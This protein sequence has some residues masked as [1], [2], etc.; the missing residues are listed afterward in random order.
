MVQRMRCVATDL[1][2]I[3]EVMDVHGATVLDVGCG[4]GGLAQRLAGQGA[5]VIGLESLTLLAGL[6]EVD[7]SRACS[8]A[9]CPG[10]ALCIQSGSIDMVLYMASFHH[11]PPPLMMVALAE[12]RGVLRETGRLVVVEPVAEPGSYLELVRLA[13]DE[14][15]LQ[16]AAAEALHG[17]SAVGLRLL[18]D[19]SSPRRTSWPPGWPLRSTIP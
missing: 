17:A 14:R 6:A 18:A 1:E 5:T 4:N 8:F 3:V 9:V 2:L 11:V 13:E 12:A 16:R 10:E 7:R 15:E 19:A